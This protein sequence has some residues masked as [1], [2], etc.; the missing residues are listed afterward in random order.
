MRLLLAAFLLASPSLLAAQAPIWQLEPSETTA[1][2]RGIHAVGNGIVWASGSSGTVLRS[3]DSGFEWQQCATPPD[4]EK[5]DFRGIWAFDDETAIVMSSGPGALSRLYR[6]TDGC[7][8]WTLLYTNPDKEGFFDAIQFTDPAHG[9][10]LGDPVHGAFTLLRTGDGGSHWT[11]VTSASQPGLAAD[12][13]TQGAFAASNSS[14]VS[15]TP[16]AHPATF[17]FVTGGTAGPFLYRAHDA[18]PAT[19]GALQMERCATQWTVSREALPLA[20]GTS[21]AGAF[22][23]AV[24]PVGGIAR[25]AVA[26]GGDYQKPAE[27]SGT[28]AFWSARS[29]RW[30]AAAVPPGG[31]RS[32]VGFLPDSATLITVGPNGSDASADYGRTWVPLESAPTDAPKGSEWN[33]LS[34]PW[35]VGPHGRIGKLNTEAVEHLL[36]ANPSGQ[37]PR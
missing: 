36:H 30:T 17:W 24:Q 28:V 34:L 21:A 37:R 27:R 7:A 18:C 5:L 10:L 22:S 11:R 16:G 15:V 12:P 6:T 14:L 33:A 29:R 1:D 13:A 19:A 20:S 23:L 9:T 26:V 8:H 3:Q 25:F 4:A 2:L 35:A 32:A 31:Y